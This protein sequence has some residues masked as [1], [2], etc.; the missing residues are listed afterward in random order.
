M[1]RTFKAMVISEELAIR[2]RDLMQAFGSH[3][4]FSNG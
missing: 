3:Y 4:T 2:A 1:H